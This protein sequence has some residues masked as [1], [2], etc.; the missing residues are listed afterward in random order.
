MPSDGPY[1][2]IEA[3]AHRTSQLGA[4]TLWAGYRQIA[5]YP[6]SVAAGATRNPSDVRASEAMGRFFAWLALARRPDIIVEVG[7][8]FGVSGMYWLHALEQN[9][10][11]HL[12]TFEPNR[13]WH[14]LAESNLRSIGTRF[15][16]VCGTFEQ[17]I[18]E[19]L[20]GRNI[21]I[22]YIDAIHTRTFVWDQF[23]R[24]L[25]FLCPHGLVL[26]DDICFSREMESCWK[27]IA[28]D[29]RVRASLSIGAEVGIVEV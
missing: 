6:H 21:D 18:G 1:A 2:E 12:I 13:R 5:D 8:A 9:R 16:A 23:Q 20:V 17:C 27:Q 26:F 25:E 19:A 29:S 3:A 11:G 28:N 14:S 24:M 10:H 15:T 22:A 4:Q 7:T